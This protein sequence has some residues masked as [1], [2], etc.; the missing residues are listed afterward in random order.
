MAG[1]GESG[2]NVGRRVGS[3]AGTV[4]VIL[5]VLA[6]TLT[7]AHLQQGRSP[8]NDLMVLRQLA[9]IVI[10][11]REAEEAQI[12][13]DPVRNVSNEEGQQLRGIVVESLGREIRIAKKK[14]DANFWL[15]IILQEHK[16]PYT[17]ANRELAHGSL[18]FSICRYPI[19]E[20]ERDCEN[21][22]YF[23]FFDS[24]RMSLFSRVTPLW[25]DEVFPPK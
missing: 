9:T 23:Y 2:S 18:T 4:A 14:E 13:V 17:N 16:Y 22:I 10:S 8:D 3:V 6:A 24:A 7:A 25:I 15:Q 1:L 11:G 21:F 5:A 19:K 20:T 12:F